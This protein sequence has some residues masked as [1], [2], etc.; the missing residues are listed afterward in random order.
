[1]AKKSNKEENGI[2]DL[3]RSFDKDSEILKKS[4]YSNIPGF[5][6]TGNY[7]LNAGLSGD[8]FKGIPLGRIVSFCGESG[9]GKSYLS[10]S[11]CREAQK[12][13]Y[14]PI[15]LDSE[16]G[17]DSTFV[18]RLGC[19]SE[20]FI[21]KQVNTIKEV[22]TFISNLCKSFDEKGITEPKVILVLDSLG[23]LTSEKESSD[24]LSG[25]TARDMTKAQDVKAMFRVNAIPLA[26]LHIPWII[27]NHVYASIGSFFPGFTQASGSGIQYNSSITMMLSAAKLEDKNNDKA[28]ANKKGEFTKNGVLVTA[29]PLKSRFCI[30]QKVRFQIPFF[31]KPNPYIGLDQYLTWE[32][33]HIARGTML[34]EK[35][36]LKLTPSEQSKCYKF[37]DGDFECWV[38]PKETARTMFIGHLH[39]TVPILEF[40]SDKVFTKEFLEKI[41]NE[42]IKPAFELPDQ[43]SFED[44][45]ELED[46]M[47][48]SVKE[49]EKEE[50][51]EE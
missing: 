13:N 4:C 8:M 23:N 41:N 5:I 44:I 39:D 28:A 2:F 24:S 14:T 33:S 11:A 27:V 32:N 21:I 45:K 19:D 15:Y 36:Y 35:E 40:F 22:N 47:G 48:I 17:I 46:S 3:V 51:P 43:S 37:K 29:K 49:E 10:V 12:E 1:M 50:E 42:V 16:G 9:T 34:N 18:E 6:S 30:P 7:I 25:K 38:N 26:K 31:C 20:N